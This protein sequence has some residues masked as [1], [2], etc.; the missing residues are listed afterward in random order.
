[1]YGLDTRVV[2]SRENEGCARVACSV[3]DREDVEDDDEGCDGFPRDPNVARSLACAGDN[4]GAR[5][6]SVSTSAS[7]GSVAD[8]RLGGTGGGAGARCLPLA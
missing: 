2:V 4:L 1:M 3:G 6:V 8:S 7:S 5:E